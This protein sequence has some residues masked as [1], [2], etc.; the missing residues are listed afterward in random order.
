MS[1][2]GLTVNV[3]NLDFTYSTNNGGQF[4]IDSG[5]VNVS[6]GS[7]ISF[8]GTFG[9]GST[10]GLVIQDGSL[11]GLD[12]TVSGDIQAAGLTFSVSGITFQYTTNNGGQF[13]IDSGS[14]TLSI[15]S[16]TITA[17]FGVNGGPGLVI[18]N[19]ALTS[20]DVA[21]SGNF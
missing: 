8:G 21:V 15:S 11:T 20:L 5:S 10:A 3:S 13:E 19:G 9:S 6:V 16:Q 1:V 12:I 7:I 17:T 4:E 14:V 2:A 18:A